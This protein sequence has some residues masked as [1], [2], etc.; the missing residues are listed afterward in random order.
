[1]TLQSAQLV[2]VPILDN[3]FAATNASID[4][5]VTALEANMIAS[6]GE[7]NVR[8]AEL[9]GEIQRLEGQMNLQEERAKR[10]ELR[11]ILCTAVILVGNSHLGEVVSFIADLIHRLP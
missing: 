3:R 2:S 11:Y 10:R 4:A 6:F 5:R 9:R 8:F 1:M 7:V